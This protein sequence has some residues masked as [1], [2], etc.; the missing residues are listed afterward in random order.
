MF[1]NNYAKNGWEVSQIKTDLQDG[2]IKEFLDKEN[3]WFNYISG[4]VDAGFGDDVDTA[5]FSA[6]GLGFSNI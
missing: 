6:Q 4:D 2:S 3:K 5:E 1:N